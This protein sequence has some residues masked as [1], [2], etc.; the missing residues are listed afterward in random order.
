MGRYGWQLPAQAFQ[1]LAVVVIGVED[2]RACF[3]SDNDN[4]SCGTR[5]EASVITS[6]SAR[7]QTALIPPA[8]F[9]LKSRCCQPAI[10]PQLSPVAWPLC[11]FLCTQHLIPQGCLLCTL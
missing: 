5:R 2:F 4:R 9:V 1:A 6:A 3:I 8:V 10:P 11:L 7:L